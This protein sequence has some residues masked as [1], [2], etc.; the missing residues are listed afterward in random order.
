MT[1]LPE[2]ETLED[3]LRLHVEALAA[4]PRPP[5]SAAHTLAQASIEAHFRQAGFG[6]TRQPFSNNGTAGIN[7]LTAPRPD[8]PDLPL[9]IV[10]AI[11]TRSPIRRVLTTMQ[12]P[13][14]L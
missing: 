11:T 12:A 14:P 5:G 3:R 10:G 13:S 2:L 1:D 9:V 4:I 8:R 6:V 7:L